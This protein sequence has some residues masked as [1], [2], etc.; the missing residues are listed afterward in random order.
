MT[1]PELRQMEKRLQRE[2]E[3]NLKIQAAR[4]K[5]D[6]ELEA[7][8]RQEVIESG[9]VNMGRAGDFRN[10]N[11]AAGREDGP[12]RDQ[13]DGDARSLAAGDDVVIIHAPDRQTPG[14]GAGH[15]RTADLSNRNARSVANADSMIPHRAARFAAHATPEVCRGPVGVAEVDQTVQSPDS[16]PAKTVRRREDLASAARASGD[17]ASGDGWPSR[18]SRACCM[19]VSSFRKLRRR[20]KIDSLEVK[21]FFAN[22]IAVFQSS[23]L[24]H[25]EPQLINAEDANVKSR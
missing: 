24:K 11:I 14:A 7:K 22:F 6:A 13:V 10:V 9:N 20:Y 23:P 3:L 16:R 2:R 25:I 15:S 5:A 12:E 8:L 21:I 18:R 1:A 4:E 19:T 17:R